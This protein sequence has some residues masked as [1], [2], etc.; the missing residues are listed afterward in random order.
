[1]AHI[2]G[3]HQLGSSRDPFPLLGPLVLQVLQG[4]LRVAYGFSTQ[5]APETAA[6]SY[7]VERMALHHG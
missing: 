2:S 5:L 4:F 7:Q 3:L 6:G 1:M